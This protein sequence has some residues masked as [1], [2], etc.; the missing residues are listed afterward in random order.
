LPLPLH[1]VYPFVLGLLTPLSLGMTLILPRSLVGQHFLGA[2]TEGRATV[3]LGVPRLYSALLAAI[4]Q[5]IAVKGGL[6]LRSFRGMLRTSIALRSATG[7]DAGKWLFTTLRRK[8][9]PRLRLLVS[10]GSALDPDVAWK[11]EGLGWRVASGYGLTETSPILTFNAPG[12]GRLDSAGL[13]LPGVQIRLAEPQP[14]FR[15]GEVLAKGANVFSGYRNLPERTRETF[16]EDGWFRTGDLGYLDPGGFLHLDGRTSSMIVLQGGENV[17][18]EKLEA[19]LEQSP[20]IREAGV[21]EDE[22][23][24]L[25]V[26]LPEPALARERDPEELLRELRA[27]VQR[28]SAALPT[29]QRLGEIVVDTQPLPRTRLGKLQRHRLV[30]RCKALKQG[31]L[32]SAEPGLE[33]ASRLS[34]EDRQLLEDP[35]ASRLWIWLGERFAAHRVTPDTD[36]RVDL[37]VDSLEWLNLTLEIRNRVGVELTDQAVARIQTVRD[38]LREGA[39]AQRALG[40]QGDVLALLREPEALLSDAELAWLEPRPFASQIL[41]PLVAALAALLMRLVFRFRAEGLEQLPGTGPYV[42]TPNHCSALDPIAVAAALGRRR[43]ART[44]W[45]GWVGILFSGPLRSRL[46][47]AV[48][49]LPVAPDAHPLSNLALAS[50]ALG[51]GYQLVWFPEGARSPTGETQRFRAGIGLLLR[52]HPVPAVPVW[53]EGAGAALP[54]GT[55]W[56]RRRAV[57]LRC[58]EPSTAEQL[59]PEGSGDCEEERIADALRSRVAALGRRGIPPR[60][61]A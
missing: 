24:L 61:G 28:I 44:Y 18:P 46:S 13:P 16:T 4:E 25:G 37:G 32:P 49:V 1:H 56:P 26:L 54:P 8:L 12:T 55:L 20:S 17:D 38:L 42:L 15:H 48:R 22:G 59:E 3:L 23:R 43:L 35:V 58:G 51:R 2:L 21:L 53:I 57:S 41:D 33:A 36:L 40:W 6:A 27:E 30:A 47:H 50:A 52:A 45:G 34:P 10:G 31:S 5:G 19:R 11:L 9:A 39:T 29:Y 60:R 7:L 14:P